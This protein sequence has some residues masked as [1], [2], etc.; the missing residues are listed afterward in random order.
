[1]QQSSWYETL[2]DAF[3]MVDGRAVPDDGI[4]LLPIMPDDDAPDVGRFSI[5]PA[6]Y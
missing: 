5:A 2:T 6:V 1:M 3:D 4:D